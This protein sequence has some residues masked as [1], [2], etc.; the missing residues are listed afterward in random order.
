MGGLGRSVIGGG[1]LFFSLTPA[2]LPGRR[3][4]EIWRRSGRL[5][6]LEEGLFTAAFALFVVIR[7]L[8]PDL[9]QP[10]FGGEKMMEIAILN[11]LSRSAYMPPYDPGFA[12]GYLNYYYYGQFIAS[13]PM[14]L[15]GI[16]PEVGFNLAVPTIFALTISHCFGLGYHLAEGRIDPDEGESGDDGAQG[17]SRAGL[18]GGLGSCVLV[19]VIG[20][21]TG[22]IQ[23]IGHLVRTGGGAIPLS[24]DYWQSSR[25]IPF[26]I[27]EFPFFSFLFADL[28]PHMIAIPFIVLAVAVALSP[29][30]DAGDGRGRA[31]WWLRWP[32]YG[33]IL[34]ALGPMNTWDVPAF[35]GIPAATLALIGAKDRGGWGALGGTLK[36]VALIALSLGLYAPFYAHFRAQYVGLDLLP[37]ESGS[38][39]MPFLLIWGFLLFVVVALLLM[40]RRSDCSADEDARAGRQRHIIFLGGGLLSVAL[41]AQGMAVPALLIPL[42]ALSAVCLL[43]ARDAAALVQRLALFVALGILSGIE[44]VTMRDFL[45]GGEWA[46]MNTVF[47]FSIQAWV[48]LGITGGSALP[49]LWRGWGRGLRGVFIVLL[50]ASLLYPLLAVSARV[51]ERFPGERPPRNTLDGTA[52]MTVGVYHWPDEDH[53]IVLRHDREALAWLWENVRGTPVIVE[54]ALGYYREG[55]LRVSSYTGLPTLVGAHQREQRPWDLVDA[56]EQDAVAIYTTTDEEHLFDLLTRHRVRYIY[57]GSLERIVYPERGVAK[58]ERLADAG[59]LSRVYRNEGVVIY[60]VPR[61]AR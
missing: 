30:T 59:R 7:L 53:S 35:W 12:G 58:F 37:A 25:V 27:N 36:G 51:E 56:R 57:V 5:I 28:H 31:L 34:G 24:F 2:R 26:T 16:A 19:A 43:A 1:G 40:W 61:G 6:L 29:A 3:F 48:L 41:L 50:A 22:A 13:I 46:R 47:K 20:N 4:H 10:W 17:L 42:L 18:W 32:I 38:P 14:K 52:Y 21:L 11:A 15:S 33:M 44:F 60:E 23:W 45:A 8:N 49:A 39:L 9:W 55:G 54:A